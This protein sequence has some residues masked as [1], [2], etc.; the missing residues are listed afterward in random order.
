MPKSFSKHK[1]IFDLFEENNIEFEQD[2]L[3]K[4]FKIT[5]N[6]TEG[7]Y[8]YESF[9]SDDEQINLL[10]KSTGLHVG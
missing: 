8:E 6:T 5:K 1:K 9:L 2:R 3:T 10:S 4:S 7:L